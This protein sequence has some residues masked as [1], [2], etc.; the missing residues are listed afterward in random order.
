MADVRLQT[1]EREEDPP[2]GLGDPL[3]AGGIRQRQGEEFVVPFQQMVHSPW[4]DGH[5]VLAQVLMDFGQTAM[6]RVAQGAD[7]RHDIETKLML[8]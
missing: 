1:V 8:R 3:E 6:L 2:L 4:G 5:T 7:P